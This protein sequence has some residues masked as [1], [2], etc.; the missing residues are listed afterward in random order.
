M[1]IRNGFV[2]NSSSSSFL[3]VG[4]EA[5]K[6][7]EEQINKALDSGLEECGNTEYRPL[8]G[9]QRYISEGDTESFPVALII[10]AEHTVRSV[11]GDEIDI[12]VFVGTTYS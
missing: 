12:K 8:I 2:S 6:L 11:L 10:A 5:S 7:T 3:V 9:I 1:K 4:V